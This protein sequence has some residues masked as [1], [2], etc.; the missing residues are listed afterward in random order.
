MISFLLTYY[1]FWFIHELVSCRTAQ[2]HD[3]IKSI[4]HCLTMRNNFY[5]VMDMLK[6]INYYTSHR[7]FHFAYMYNIFCK[8]ITYI[9]I[10]YMGMS[11]KALIYHFYKLFCQVNS[12]LRVCISVKVSFVKLYFTFCISILK[13]KLAE[14]GISLNLD[15]YSLK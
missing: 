7:V 14:F 10:Y 11:I 12:E 15:E 5:F 13:I 9:Y 2:I 1:L 6:L 4:L 3:T 8:L